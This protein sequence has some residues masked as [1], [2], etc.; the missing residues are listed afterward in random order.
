MC[1]DS[2][3]QLF[4]KGLN[5]AVTAELTYRLQNDP[6]ALERFH[7]S[8]G[9]DPKKLYPERLRIINELFPDTP[10]RLLKD[11]F[12]ALQLY[13]L[14]EL[15]EKAKP[16]AL[17][18]ALPLREIGR[19]PNAR[20]RP[21]TFYSKASVLI[22][23]NSTG[24]SD[25]TAEKIESFFKALNTRNEVTTVTAKPSLERT[26]AL[27][28]MKR[29]IQVKENSFSRD[30]VLMRKRGSHFQ[31]GLNNKDVSGMEKEAEER[32]KW[33]KERK[34]KIKQEIKQKKEELEKENEKFQ[35]AVSAVMD[36][37][38][39]SEGW[40]KL[41]IFHMILLLIFRLYLINVTHT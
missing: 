25:D 2:T 32:E 23:D 18:P 30:T 6:I 12:E 26:E 9:L 36:E 19:L 16:R 3:S 17:R 24:V 28:N 27:N 5:K 29:S 13:D 39:H 11:V 31:R 1:L 10:V 22:I 7:Q 35:I 15:L 20:N 4:L 40:F 41:K 33:T 8:F 14:V 38:I 21:T 34:P 37:W